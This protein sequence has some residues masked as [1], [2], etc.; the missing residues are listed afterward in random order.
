VGREAEI[1]RLVAALEEAGQGR[2]PA[3]VV[4]GESGAG[5]TRLLREFAA[6]AAERGATVLFGRCVDCGD[7]G[8]PYWPIIEALRSV[9]I[10]AEPGWAASDDRARFFEA[11]LDRLEDL[12]RHSPVAL[13]VDDLHWADRSTR[14]LLGFL[15]A[16]LAGEPGP[17]VV[18]AVRSE[19]LVPGHP[20]V[21]LLAE[22]RRSRRAEFLP[23]DR[24]GR[25][26]V[27]AQLT[28]IL[29]QAPEPGLL[30]EIWRRS[31]GNPFYVEELLAAARSGHELTSTLQPIL[32]ARLGALSPDARAA[33]GAVAASVGPVPHRI[34][35]EAAGIPEPAL[36]AGLRECVDRHVL[37]GDAGAGT[38]TFRHSLLR[39]AAYADLLPGETMRLHSAYGRA[40]RSQASAAVADL[41][42]V[43]S[44]L[45]AAGEVEQAL[46][47]AVTAGEAS[48]AAGGYA[49]AHLQYE[50]AL[51]LAG[52]PDRGA[53]AERA[54]EAAQL[55]GEPGRAVELV[56]IALEGARPEDASRLQLALGRARWAA[57]DNDGALGAYDEAVRLLVDPRTGEGVRALAAAAEARMLAGR[58]GESRRLAGEALALARR[59]ALPHE[60]AEILGT[61]GVD[62]ALLGDAD[63]AMA[64]LDQAVVAA[65]KAG[66]P[67]PLARAWLNRAQ[68]LA[69]PLNRLEEAAQV[70]A[71]DLARL[72]ELG[73][74]RSYGAILAAT[75]AN[76]LFRAGRWNDAD[77]VIETAL[78]DR[79]TGEA[80][81]EVTLARCRL[82]VGRGQFAAAHADL[83]RVDH[84]WT[85]AVAPR[86]QAPLLTLAAGLA[87]WEGRTGDARE[88]VARAL[89]IVAGSDDSWL[90]AAL[91]WHGIRAEG[92][93][94]TRARAL[95]DR[96]DAKTTADAAA[97]LLDRARALQEGSAPAVR[98][99]VAAY[100]ALC[101]A[102]E[103]R[104]GGA[105]DPDIWAEAAGLWATLDQP[106]PSAYA[107]YREA[108]A[109]LATT[110]RSARAATTLREAHAAAVG[111]GAQPLQ[112][113][114][115]D[116]AGRARLVLPRSDDGLPADRSAAAHVEAKGSPT[117]L[118][119][120]TAR[121]REVLALMADGRTNREIAAAL[122][123]AEK[124][125]SVHVSHILA[126]LGVRSRVQAVAV[127]HQVGVPRR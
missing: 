30:E 55:A 118:D 80:A 28:S 122:Y 116:L 95:G 61:L 23:L 41:A 58:Y 2:A 110:A 72:R 82:A 121:E 75:L 46:P 50:R 18:A 104:A 47:A 77:P 96:L 73:L 11:V 9:S 51:E 33:A 14:D 38:Y 115:E 112:Q 127:A 113:A 56:A 123:I 16:N 5:K 64:A 13:L 52:G 109:V 39:E 125:A 8:P 36:L 62:L 31:E 42:A 92:D 111:L 53:L 97:A 126:K 32:E 17:L 27:A 57:G 24:L 79:P 4:E 71:G 119:A 49:E 19:A 12:G 29:G 40:L 54:A 44:H 25:S 89:D 63:A 59:L 34:L 3:I 120:L 37:V 69:G 94:A 90:V 35:A 70:A 10:A 67:R 88:A 83:E 26:D 107:R 65:Q 84:S 124:T 101:R 114:I 7:A 117:P 66:R 1:A 103:R 68:V 87:L 99:V 74:G 85:Q 45:Y 108:G 21:P 91:L 22:L 102:E 6:L 105:D 43:A 98:P 86:Y 15:L 76:T 78:A 100:D 60:E 106:Y 20:L 48:E 81:I 93:G